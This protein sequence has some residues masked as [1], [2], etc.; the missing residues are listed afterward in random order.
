MRITSA[1]AVAIKATCIGLSDI[2]DRTL[3]L[4][5]RP[6]NADIVSFGFDPGGTWKAGFDYKGSDGQ[7]EWW[8]NNGSWCR[9]I[10]YTPTGIACFSN[11]VCSPTFKGCIFQ[12]ASFSSLTSGAG[13]GNAVYDTITRS[14]AVLYEVAIVANPN[15]AGSGAYAD[16]YYGDL[17]IGTGFGSTV[18]DYIFWCQRSTLP[19]SLYGSGGG[20]LTV[21]AC[22]FYSGAEYSSIGTGGTYTI[23]FKI[24]GYNSSATGDGTTI[25]LKQI[26]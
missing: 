18:T 10:M 11:T 15:G 21:N 1:G 14:G 8:T 17:F 22:M 13:T 24:N 20:N 3:V 7:L 5:S 19:R 16:F 25:F 9:R 4:G 6:G 12:G 2:A 26:I 23:R